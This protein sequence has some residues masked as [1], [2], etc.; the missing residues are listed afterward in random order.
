MAY[1]NYENHSSRPPRN[2]R[3]GNQY[4]N[5]R[6]AASIPE[7]EPLDVPENYVDAA[8]QV[9]KHLGRP[10]TKDSSRLRFSI[11]TSK[12][13]N[14][15]TLVSDIYN[16]ESRRTEEM[17]LQ[18]SNSKLQMLRIRILYEAGRN[19]SEV[20]PFV[21]SSKLLEYIKGI[22]MNREKF[23]RFAH[24]MEALVAYHRYYGGRD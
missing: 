14:I 1:T 7:I 11:T 10:N 9:M 8:E 24:Y 5:K 22:Q 20:K 23:I 16:I 12:I 15:L 6:T 2:L 21:K 4:N 3:G 17:I 19:E 13:R 18:E